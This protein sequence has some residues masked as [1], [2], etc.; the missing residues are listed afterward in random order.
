MQLAEVLRTVVLQNVLT[1]NKKLCLFV[2][3]VLGCGFWKGYR[4]KAGTRL[5][6]QNYL[7]GFMNDNGQSLFTQLSFPWQMQSKSLCVVTDM[8]QYFL[9]LSA[10]T[11]QSWKKG[12]K[13]CIIFHCSLYVCVP[14]GNNC[15]KYCE[16][17]CACVCVSACLCLLKMQ[18]KCTDLCLVQCK[19]MCSSL[20]AVHMH[21]YWKMFFLS[22]F[23][24]TS[25]PKIFSLPNICNLHIHMI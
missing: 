9:L 22:Y 2:G 16:R 20:K 19:T 24:T 25:W 21:V 14:Y 10:I 1:A 6:I 7:S 17:V 23:L 18:C 12:I 3:N 8:V 11:K 4:P 5:A 13:Q 15:F